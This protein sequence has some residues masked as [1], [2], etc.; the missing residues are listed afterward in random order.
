MLL[1]LGLHLPAMQ[2]FLG[3]GAA[4]LAALETSR[5]ACHTSAAAATARTWGLLLLLH[6]QSQILGQVGALVRLWTALWHDH[7]H[8]ASSQLHVPAG[9][10]D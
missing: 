5:Q 4:G 3:L 7:A 1:P 2:C 10:V 8:A 6:R 9:P